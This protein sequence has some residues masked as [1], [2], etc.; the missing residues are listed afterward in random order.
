[1]TIRNPDPEVP[2]NLDPLAREVLEGLRGHA[3]AEAIVLGGGVA[4]Q[5]YCEFRTTLDIDARWAARTDSRTGSD[6]GGTTWVAV[7]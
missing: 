6:R 4:L 3:A 5:H 1:M 2:A 7:T